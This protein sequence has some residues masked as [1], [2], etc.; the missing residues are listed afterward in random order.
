MN[1]QGRK[2]KIGFS[3]IELTTGWI[4]NLFKE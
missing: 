2:I 4:N 1:L 3:L